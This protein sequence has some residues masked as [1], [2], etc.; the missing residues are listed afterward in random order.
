MLLSKE[1]SLVLLLGLMA[2]FTLSRDITVRIR[3]IAVAGAIAVAIAAA[4]PAAMLL[5][6][7][8]RV[9][10]NYLLWQLLRRPNHSLAFY[11]ITVPPAL[12]VLLL[13]LAAAGLWLLRRQASWP[14]RLLLCWAAAP[15]AFFEFWPVKGFQYLLPAAPVVA[16][17]GAR[18]LLQL[19]IPKTLLRWDIPDAERMVRLI[20]ALVIVVSLAA[21]SWQRIMPAASTTYLAG[22]GGLPAGRE[23]GRWIDAH[24]PLGATFLAL[25]PSMANV[26]EFYGHRKAYGL[27]VSPNPVNRN[28][29]YEAVNNPDGQ[30]RQGDLQYLVW[31]SYSAARAPAFSTRILAYAEKYHAVAIHTEHLT[32]ADHGAR[33]E[34]PV[35]TIYEA[36]P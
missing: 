3:D 12:G 8:S 13:A 5:A 32:I 4:F 22:A 10:G 23:A 14:E 2:F 20:A 25:G 19:P 11:P 18:A 28:P 17:L 36:R 29:S 15:I 1:T 31:D 35:I 30:L 26:I 34:K 16:V 24:V 33:V 7:T 6:G 27:S 9:G 21:P